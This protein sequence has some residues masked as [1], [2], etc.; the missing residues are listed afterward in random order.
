MA[1]NKTVQNNQNVQ[2]FIDQVE[3]AQKRQDC[4]TL[5]A[6]MSEVTGQPAAMWGDAI[7]GFGTYHYRYESGREGDYFLVGFSPRK[8]NLTLYIMGGFENYEALMGKIGKHST[9][10]S[11]LYVKTLADLD[12][13]VL[14]ELVRQSSEYAARM[15]P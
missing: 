13:G 8:A 14:R 6:L 12:M 1:E 7:V 10:K 4:G 15:Y 5:I 3:D 11:C 9:G 2:A